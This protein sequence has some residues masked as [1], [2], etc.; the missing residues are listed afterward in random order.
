VRIRVCSRG[1]WFPATEPSCSL[2]KRMGDH[3]TI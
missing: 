2:M 3:P 1:H